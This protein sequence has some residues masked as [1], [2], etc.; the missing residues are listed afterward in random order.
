MLKKFE[1]LSELD[2]A[3]LKTAKIE[4]EKNGFHRANVDEMAARLEI[5]KGTI[6]RHFGNKAQLF[7]S[8]IVFVLKDSLV[9]LEAVR[10][11]KSF[12][13][14]LRIYL[15][16]FISIRKVTGNFITNFFSEEI[17]A[18]IQEEMGKN[19]GLKDLFQFIMRSRNDVIIILKEI[20]D[21]G[22]KGKVLPDNMNSLIAAEIIFITVN[23]FF[24]TH[25]S[26]CENEEKM[27]LKQNFSLED[28]VKELKAFIYRGIGFN[29]S[30][31]VTK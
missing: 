18:A 28:G 12:E 20:L 15:D 3:I 9:V 7:V 5:G 11:E 27:G 21:N 17:H 8:V 23:N 25:Y 16:N 14:A 22:I 19:G 31:S 1:N 4:F 10:N 26:I 24:I 29:A 2:T 30:S 13:D 6:Y